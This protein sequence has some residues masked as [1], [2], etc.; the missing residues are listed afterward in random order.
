MIL[1]YILG[2]MILIV[3]VNEIASTDIEELEETHKYF[4]NNEII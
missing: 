2:A 4:M 1:L 3:T